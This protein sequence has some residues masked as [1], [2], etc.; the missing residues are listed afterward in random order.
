MNELTNTE[1]RILFQQVLT[2]KDVALIGLKSVEIDQLMIYVS[3]EIQKYEAMAY[4]M[5]VEASIR[6]EEYDADVHTPEYY[7]K[8]ITNL[9]QAMT[10]NEV[11]IKHFQTG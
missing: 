3:S 2:Y 9:K 7:A 8:H 11:L 6:Y 5:F 4:Q 10:V 1:L